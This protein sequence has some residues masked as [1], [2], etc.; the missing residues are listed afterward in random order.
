MT[1]L[2]AIYNCQKVEMQ[3][4]DKTFCE[5]E[6]T[7]KYKE[8]EKKSMAML[9]LSEFMNELK[10]NGTDGTS[11][12]NLRNENEQVKSRVATI[13]KLK[14]ELKKKSKLLIIMELAIPFNP[15]TGKADDVYNPDKKFRPQK[16]ATTVALMLK[17]EANENEALKETLMHRAGVETWDTSDASVLNDVDKKI[18]KKY[19]VPSV[20][21][22]PVVNV[23]IPVMTK[24]YSRD[25]IINVQRD[26]VTAQIIGEKPLAIQANEFFRDIA[27]EEYNDFQQKCTSGEINMTDKQKQERTLQIFGKVPVSDDH[28]VNY[29]IAM[30]LPLDNK[31]DLKDDYAGIKEDDVKK[32]LVQTR[33]SKGLGDAISKYLSEEWGKYDV[34]F[35]F[36]EID[37]CCPAEGDTPAE[38]GQGT[39][40]EKPEAIPES[41]SKPIEDALRAYF[42][43]QD[44][45]E[46]TM[47]NSVRIS[48]YDENVER[49]LCSALASVVDS[50]NPFLTKDVIRQHREFI[51][52]A[53]GDV[54][55]ELLLSVE[56]DDEDRA[57]GSLN[58]EEAAKL[59]KEVSLESIMQEDDVLD[60]EVI[61]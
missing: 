47:I 52:V 38:I 21:T 28:P 55:S 10:E 25:Y 9:S 18:F 16:S 6:R 22:F 56:M 3:K 24:Q 45:L 40:Y 51:T 48:K 31:Y 30:E 54:G 33:R 2:F 27:Y 53:L 7:N 14:K 11:K 8:K 1:F 4:D 61:E 34:H 26:P 17:E 5:L 44:D 32:L 13:P 42:D 12:Y 37:M 19:R 58:Q 46:A 35:D 59:S 29:L 60:L 20:Y 57:D 39:T 43:S 15:L 36:V 49:Q 23:D 50:D 41:N